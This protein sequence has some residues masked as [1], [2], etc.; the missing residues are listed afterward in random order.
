MARDARRR[1]PKAFS[2]LTNAI[3]GDQ[4]SPFEGR[5]VA[6]VDY[7]RAVEEGTRGGAFPPVRN[8]LDWVK[9]TR[10]VPDDPAM[11]QADLAYVIAR[12]IARRGTPAQP[13][14]GPAFE[15]NKARAQRRIDA[16]VQAALREMMR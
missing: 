1:A 12:A 15:D 11:D 5:V 13:F 9:V 7:A 14:M 2:T 6:G 8:I 4:V 10:Q 16:A 3:R